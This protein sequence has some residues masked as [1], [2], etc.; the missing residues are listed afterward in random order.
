MYRGV[1]YGLEVLFSSK[2]VICV[3]RVI[4]HKNWIQR[5]F[6]R[7]MVDSMKYRWSKVCVCVY[8][9]QLISCLLLPIAL[10]ICSIGYQ[11]ETVCIFVVESLHDTHLYNIRTYKM[12]YPW[13]PLIPSWNHTSGWI[14]ACTQYIHRFPWMRACRGFLCEVGPIWCSHC[15]LSWPLWFHSGSSLILSWFKAWHHGYSAIRSRTSLRQAY[16][17]MYFGRRTVPLSRT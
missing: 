13:L 14:H 12:L 5:K 1:Y 2:W 3:P 10:A 15:L 17:H 6:V 11:R 4:V 9:L 16:T 8:Y 7:R